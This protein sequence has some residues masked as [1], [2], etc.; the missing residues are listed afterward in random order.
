MNRQDWDLLLFGM[1]ATEIVRKDNKVIK[2][3]VDPTIIK[4]K[5]L[6]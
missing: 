3:R 4:L 6:K 1:K 5:I 2:R